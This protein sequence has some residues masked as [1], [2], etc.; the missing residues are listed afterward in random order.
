M[1]FDHLLLHGVTHK[2]PVQMHRLFLPLAP[3][4]ADGLALEAQGSLGTF[5]QHGVHQ[6]QVVGAHQVHACRTP[7]Q[8][9]QQKPIVQPLGV[10]LADDA[11][12]LEDGALQGEARHAHLL[13][14]NLHLLEQHFELD[15]NDHLRI[16]LF[17]PNL[18]Q[19]ATDCLQ[20]GAKARHAAALCLL[21]S[22]EHLLGQSHLADL[23]RAVA[24]GALALGLQPTAD[25]VLAKNVATGGDAT[26]IGLHR[27][28][29]NGAIHGVLLKLLKLFQDFLEVL[30]AALQATFL[31][32]RHGLRI[33]Q[34]LDLGPLLL[35]LLIVFGRRKVCVF[36]VQQP[37]QLGLVLPHLLA[38]LFE[39]SLIVLPGAADGII[40]V[41]VAVVRGEEVAELQHGLTSWLAVGSVQVQRPLAACLTHS[42]KVVFDW[43]G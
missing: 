34:A 36:L 5:R 38:M 25:A 4:S 14:G 32:L 43:N 24:G 8:R 42:H 26:V 16:L 6:N 28:H 2:E 22:A 19:L 33:L 18:S 31:L 21:G 1:L 15:E 9:Q 20:L 40:D 29:A 11:A 12:P 10:E 37:V 3:H 39:C 35:H 13:Q 17:A 23:Q 27:C 7:L 30:D 41:L